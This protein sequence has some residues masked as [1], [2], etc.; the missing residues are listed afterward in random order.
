MEMVKTEPPT[1]Q[2]RIFFWSVCPARTLP[3]CMAAGTL[4]SHPPSLLEMAMDAM[5]G[6]P[7][8]AAR[9]TES[10]PP[11]DHSVTVTEYI[12]SVEELKR[13]GA[14]T[15]LPASMVWPCLTNS[16]AVNPWA[17]VALTPS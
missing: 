5:G 7:A 2:I 16:L 8:E 15:L 6:L 14:E 10:R 1:L 4:L 3:K 11:S 9:M 17:K 12:P 13:S